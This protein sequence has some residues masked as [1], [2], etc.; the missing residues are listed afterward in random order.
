M[1]FSQLDGIGGTLNYVPKLARNV[2]SSEISFGART[3]DQFRT[4]LDM[5]RR[6][7]EERRWGIRVNALG[8]TGSQ[9]TRDSA[10]NIAGLSAAL[11]FR[12]DNLRASLV[13]EQ[14][15][16]RCRTSLVIHQN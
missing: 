3:T 12:N 6:F 8:N 9:F 16:S 1:L 11:D 14:V 15:E 5:S 10:Q 13:V 4:H 2:D 7:G